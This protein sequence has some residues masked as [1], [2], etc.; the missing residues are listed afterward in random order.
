MRRSYVVLSA[1]FASA[2]VAWGQSPP[3]ADGQLVASESLS[4]T[5]SWDELD[6]LSKFRFPR[7][8]YDEAKNQQTFEAQRIVYGSDGLRIVGY[9]YKPKETAGRKLPAILFNRGGTADFGALTPNELVN[10]YFWAKEG[11]VVLASNY[12]GGGGSEGVDEWGGRDVNDVLNL[13]PLAKNLGFIDLDNLF[14]LGMSRGGPMTYIAI[15][16]GMPVNA[17]AVIAGVTDL[18]VQDMQRPEFLDGNDPFLRQIGW[19]GWKKIW[20]DFEHRAAEHFAERSAVCWPEQL[21]V[22]LLLLHSRTDSR[23][24]VEHALTLANLLEKEGKEYELVIYAHDG[25]SLPLRRKDR[26]EHIVSWFKNHVK[27]RDG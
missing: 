14:L 4:L 20:P 24:P 22:P 25:H 21:N 9:L 16:R 10:F 5:K 11:F 8:E 19:L 23:V 18:R 15:K 2:A 27:R 3:L 17:A 1:L 6:E 26:D 13:V 7:A 12:R